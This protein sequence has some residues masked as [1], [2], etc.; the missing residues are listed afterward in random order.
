M[1]DRPWECEPDRWECEPDRLDFEADG[2]RCAMRR[3]HYRAWCG[4]VGVGPEHPLFGLPTN[5]PLKLPA[6]WFEGRK[7]DQGTGPIDLVIHMMSGAKSMND[8]CP[9]SLAFQVHGGLGYAED[10]VPDPN[11]IVPPDGRWW[12]GFDCGHAGDYMP[13][14]QFM[15]KYLEQMVDSMPEHVRATMRKVVLGTPNRYR[16]QPYVVAECQSL[17]AQLN[18]YAKLM[19]NV[20]ANSHH[21]GD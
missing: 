7:F 17:A 2:L 19:E 18:A 3:N 9:I 13:G 14:L 20:D 21:R 16:D 12:F 6:S 5:H 8:A 1:T 10:H 4:Y 15:D 11:R